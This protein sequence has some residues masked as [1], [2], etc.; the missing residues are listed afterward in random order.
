MNDIKKDFEETIAKS[1]SDNK[2]LEGEIQQLHRENGRMNEEKSEK[3]HLLKELTS[4]NLELLARIASLE[5]TV[6]PLYEDMRS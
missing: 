4:K 2:F 6:K 5:T 3:D 1:L